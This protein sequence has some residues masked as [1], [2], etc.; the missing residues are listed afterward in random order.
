MV[1]YVDGDLFN[2]LPQTS[3]PKY[4]PHVVN[5]IGRMGSGFAAA[6]M[7]KYPRIRENY[8]EWFKSK[9]ENKPFQLGETQYVIVQ[10]NPTIVVCN[11]IGQSGIVGPNNHKPIRYVALVKCMQNVAEQIKRCCRAASIHAPMFGAGLAQGKWELI[12]ELIDE[13]W[14]DFPVTIYR[15]GGTT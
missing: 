2:L 6:A 1:N 13:C 12:E 7:K 11:M 4:I 5:N 10:E 9:N 14:R 8:L 15:L 3:E